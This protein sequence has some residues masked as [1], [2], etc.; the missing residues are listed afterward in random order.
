MVITVLVVLALCVR[1][2]RDSTDGITGRLPTVWRE[3]SR[4][5]NPTEGD[6]CRERH[7][8]GALIPGDSG[9]GDMVQETA[10]LMAQLHSSEE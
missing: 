2:S 7:R 6:S 4:R 5:V 9:S 1:A 8:A 10:V 3:R